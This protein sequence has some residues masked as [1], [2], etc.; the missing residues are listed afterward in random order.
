MKNHLSLKH[1]RVAQPANW[2]EDHTVSTV[3]VCAGSGGKA[4]S[5]THADVYLTGIILPPNYVYHCNNVGEMSHHDVL[6][7][8][9]HGTAVILCE[10]SNTERGFLHIYGALLQTRAGSDITIAL[11][12][13]DCDP[14]VIA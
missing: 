9:S 6:A 7:A 12:K 1:V 10:H 11:A 14:L 2:T 4:L 5:G 3:A 8:V 13:L